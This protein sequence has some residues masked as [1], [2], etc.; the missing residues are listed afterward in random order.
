[1]F[2]FCIICASF[3]TQS[4]KPRSSLPIVLSHVPPTGANVR[5]TGNLQRR[6][7]PSSL[8]LFL[9]PPKPIQSRVLYLK[10]AFTEFLEMP[11]AGFKTRACF[12]DAGYYRQPTDSPGGLLEVGCR[13]SLVTKH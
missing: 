4:S 3:P 5:T 2:E 11:L 9:F 6:I 1:M 7:S 12:E 8:P 10:P 13:A